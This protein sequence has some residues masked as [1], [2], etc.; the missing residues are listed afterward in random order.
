ML[1]QCLSFADARNRGPAARS[2]Q[3]ACGPNPTDQKTQP[4]G[5]LPGAASVQPQWPWQLRPHPWGRDWM[6][7]TGGLWQ[8]SIGCHEALHYLLVGHISLQMHLWVLT[9]PSCSSEAV[10]VLPM[11]ARGVGWSVFLL[12]LGLGVE[13]H[14]DGGRKCSSPGSLP[15]VQCKHY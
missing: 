9:V 13:G 12:Y 7:L 1:R 5:S 3:G 10:S 2:C 14:S 6:P 4:D 8:V 15:R 11:L